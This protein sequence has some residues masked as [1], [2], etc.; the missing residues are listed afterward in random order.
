MTM[1]EMLK[2]SPELREC[3]FALRH[4]E[5]RLRSLTPG[6][7]TNLNIYNNLID[8][9]LMLTRYAK[10]VILRLYASK[11]YNGKDIYIPMPSISEHVGRGC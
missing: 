7:N 10:Q 4:V 9:R 6:I 8:C 1:K 11:L 3:K 2:I 5:S